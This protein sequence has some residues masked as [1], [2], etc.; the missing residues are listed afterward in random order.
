MIKPK[1]LNNEE[2]LR[3]KF[4]KPKNYSSDMIQRIRDGL[5]RENSKPEQELE[6]GNESSYFVL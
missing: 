1:N 2:N 4:G 6:S 3:Q 5:Q